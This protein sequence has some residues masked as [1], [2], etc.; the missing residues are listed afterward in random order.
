M[1]SLINENRIRV[2][3]LRKFL[4]VISQLCQEGV[5]VVSPEERGEIMFLFNDRAICLNYGLNNFNC[6]GQS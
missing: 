3:H 1:V 2:K 6:V 5:T 4:G